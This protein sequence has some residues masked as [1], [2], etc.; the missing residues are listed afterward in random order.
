[1]RTELE[2]KLA[3]L[4][5]GQATIRK[6]HQTISEKNMKAKIAQTSVVL[7]SREKYEARCLEVQQLM[8]S[9]TG[10]PPKEIEKV[11]LK[12]ESAQGSAKKADGEYQEAVAKLRDI[13]SKWEQDWRVACEVGLVGGGNLFRSNQRCLS[14]KQ[15]QR[16]EQDRIDFMRQSLWTYA[17]LV[18]TACVA[19]D[20][21]CERIRV[22]L[23]QLDPAGDMQSFIERNR[24]GT[25]VPR[26][27]F[28][29][30]VITKR[31]KLTCFCRLPAP[32][33]YINFYTRS[34]APSDGVF[35][36]PAL[37]ATQGSLS[38]LSSQMSGLDL[39]GQNRSND[40]IQ[41]T[42]SNADKPASV[43][44]TP[45]T[46]Y[47]LGYDAEKKASDPNMSAMPRKASIRRG[48]STK[49]SAST[50]PAS[51]QAP[52]PAPAPQDNDGASEVYE[53]ED[54]LYFD[55]DPYD[56][57]VPKPVICWI[58]VNY[59]YVPQAKEELHIKKGM[60]LPVIQQQEDGW[61]EGEVDD[62]TGR[63]RRGLFPSNVS[64]RLV[65]VSDRSLTPLEH[66]SLLALSPPLRPEHLDFGRLASNTRQGR[67]NVPTSQ[68]IYYVFHFCL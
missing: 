10:L 29:W 43:I 59:E 30:T 42:P 64:F 54:D 67:H 65:G 28:S 63:R 8:S 39:K 6:Q 13:H 26:G 56:L 37:S 50:T 33:G 49:G 58:R 40:S 62:G 57:S 27:F 14:Q 34:S 48:G 38:S 46:D 44:N 5:V 35:A 20:E 61:W 12:I 25:A 47:K 18:S 36:S 60:T 16:L 21:G 11:R 1:M 15:F 41:Q 22:S 2:R 7:K 19:E 66:P 9:R 24:T 17:N 52:P 68:W 4:I 3:E 31:W 55:Y 51:S 23:E 32:L 53:A 45:R